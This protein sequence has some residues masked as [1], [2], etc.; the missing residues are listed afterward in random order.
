MPRHRSI[1]GTLAGVLVAATA[2]ACADRSTLT[3]PVHGASLQ[4]VANV[5]PGTHKHAPR[6]QRNSHKYRDSGK[7][8]AIGRDGNAT[9]QARALL[10]RDGVTTL[11]VTTGELDQGGAPGSIAKVQVKAFDR[12]DTSQVRWIETYTPDKKGDDG[13]I[14]EKFA[15]LR[16]NDLLQVKTHVDGIDRGTD[17]VTLRE[18]VKRR[19]DLAVL[20]VDAPLQ[21][22]TYRQV[23]IGATV[24]ELNGDVGAY[25]DCVLS[26]DG[27]EVDRARHIWVDAGGSAPVSCAFSYRFPTTGTFQLTVALDGVKPGDWDRKNNSATTQISVV[28]PSDFYTT[29][30]VQDMHREEEYNRW[31][32]HTESLDSNGTVAVEDDHSETTSHGQWRHVIFHSEMPREVP[33]PVNLRMTHRS[34]SSVVETVSEAFDLGAYSYTSPD[35]SERGGCDYA[36]DVSAE[37]PWDI[38]FC[39]MA[40][41]VGDEPWKLSTTVDVERWAGLATYTSLNYVRGHGAWTEQFG[42]AGCTMSGPDGDDYCYIDNE[43]GYDPD[44]VEPFAPP[45]LGPTYDMD[46]DVTGA[47]GLSFGTTVSAQMLHLPKIG[48]PVQQCST[49]SPDTGTYPF[50]TTCYTHQQIW[51]WSLGRAFNRGP[52][53]EQ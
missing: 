50:T 33:S 49:V 40:S 28:T 29:I 10:A 37:G 39:S 21:V 27:V 14:K 18:R 48:F 9:V 22:A 15:D 12:R 32:T 2:T 3:A 5:H 1:R 13:T 25:A 36:S 53:T 30:E 31:D 23:S 24:A 34:G 43:A 17:V 52:F 6:I 35:Y 44:P 4:S 47:D 7:K 19:P 38:G 51:D 46:L 42:A 45:A 26:V 41:R 8:P 11:D 16:A 20:T